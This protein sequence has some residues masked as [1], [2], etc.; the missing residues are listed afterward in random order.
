MRIFLIEPHHDDAVFSLGGLMQQKQIANGITLVT[1]FS[2]SIICDPRFKPGSQKNV[3]RKNET[4]KVLSLLGIDWIPLGL[5]DLDLNKSNLNNEGIFSDLVRKI[6]KYVDQNNIVLL[7]AGFG[8]NPHHKIVGRLREIFKNHILYEDTTPTMS[9]SRLLDHFMPLYDQLYS[10]YYPYYYDISKY[11]DK[12]IEIASIYESQFTKESCLSLKSHARNV[13]IFAKHTDYCDNSL[14]YAERIYIPRERLNLINY[15][16][17]IDEKSKS[18]GFSEV[19]LK[20]PKGIEPC[21]R[22]TARNLFGGK[23]SFR[24][25]STLLYKAAKQIDSFS[26]L[27]GN[28]P[29]LPYPT[30]GALNN[31]EIYVIIYNVK[32]VDQ[33]VYS[34]NSESHKLILNST[35]I[36]I[37]DFTEIIEDQEWGL[38]TSFAI[39]LSSKNTKLYDK[40]GSRAIQL[41]LLEAGHV[42]QNLL[43]AANL[44][45]IN[46]VEIGG[47]SKQRI[48]TS[49]NILHAEVIIL[50]SKTNQYVSNKR[51]RRVYNLNEPKQSFDKNL[52]I[53]SPYSYYTNTYPKDKFEI[54]ITRAKIPLKN[55]YST[56]LSIA[57]SKHEK[58]IAKKTSIIKAICE[59]DEIYNSFSKVPETLVY[60]D[61]ATIKYNGRP[62][63]VEN[64][65]LDYIQKSK[66]GK[67]LNKTDHKKVNSHFISGIEYL[68]G[69]RI[70][71][72]S[73]SI[74]ISKRFWDQRIW[75][76]S[77]GYG[78]SKNLKA[79]L[80]HSIEELCEKII[81]P[82]F[83]K[84]K[85]INENS[86][87]NKK[88]TILWKLIKKEIPDLLGYYKITADFSFV[89]LK[90]GKLSIHG[91]SAKT[92]FSE[93]L[94]KASE[95]ILA[96]YFE[97]NQEDIPLMCGKSSYCGNLDNFLIEN[98]LSIAYTYFKSDLITNN[99]ITKAII[100]KY[101]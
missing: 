92:S 83:L 88:D 23:V 94:L 3:V 98:K 46:A 33:G 89:F 39:V 18:Q 17:H 61:I 78:C 54:Y 56:G 9:Y 11:I 85:R 49:L 62:V 52:L 71:L 67:T 24:E 41:S 38:G 59:A 37:K 40:Y 96:K 5:E 13:A 30:A 35:I 19:E 47:F 70:W 32:G 50:F 28:Y 29:R 12:K 82:Y 58:T 45:K 99:Y 60:T 1:V 8:N 31:T 51:L 53:S 81:V 64:I 2:E 91:S 57:F 66:L 101:E 16:I 97:G 84:V 42:C 7:P 75:P 22:L 68:T 26:Y 44:L 34:Y 86:R 80:K 15:F 69:E 65:I 93:A 21:Q 20:I 87:L 74:L 77:I 63:P 27:G 4:Q 79:A 55:H 14:H 43:L 72:P 48:N 100:Y 6:K 25:L 95:E 76:T 90:S 73:D 36:S 10:S